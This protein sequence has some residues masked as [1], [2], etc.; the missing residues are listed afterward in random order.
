MTAEGPT[1]GQITAAVAIIGIAGFGLFN[2][3]IG[4]DRAVV[5]R[6]I[7]GM[8]EASRGE[9]IYGDFLRAQRELD[10]ATEVVITSRE[11]KRY[12]QMTVTTLSYDL[13]G[14]PSGMMCGL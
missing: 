13:D 10:A 12:G 8:L 6:C 1:T 11:D 14:R 9:G 7:G 5:G 2:A 4:S 3:F